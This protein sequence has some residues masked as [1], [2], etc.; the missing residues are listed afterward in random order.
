MM[1]S[2]ET[3]SI[4]IHGGA[5]STIRPLTSTRPLF[6]KARRISLSGKMHYGFASAI[7]HGW[8]KEPLETLVLQNLQGEPEIPPF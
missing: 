5:K 3:I 6:P 2:L 8:N 7:L 1:A 4:D